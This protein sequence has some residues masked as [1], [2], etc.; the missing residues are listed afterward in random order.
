[1]LRLQYPH[2]L[3][4]LLVGPVLHALVGALVPHLLLILPHLHGCHF[5]SHGS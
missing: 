4:Y 3:D 1:M 2:A 5:G